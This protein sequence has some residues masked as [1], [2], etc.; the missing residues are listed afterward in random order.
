MQSLDFVVLGLGLPSEGVRIDLSRL[1]GLKINGGHTGFAL[2]LRG[3]KSEFC[4]NRG[5]SSLESSQKGFMLPA[6]NSSSVFI[7]ST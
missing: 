4:L 7:S 5:W 2:L 3:T 1:P 6:L